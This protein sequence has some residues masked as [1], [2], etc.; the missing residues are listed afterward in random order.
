MRVLICAV[1]ALT[2]AAVHA[3]QP[4]SPITAPAAV[5]SGV[6]T[7]D[8][9]VLE[10]VPPGTPVR[11]MFLKEITSHTAHPGDRFRMRV[12][13]PVYINGKPVIPVGTFAWGEV[14]SLESNGAAGHAGKIAARLLY[15]DLPQGHLPLRGEVANKGGGNGGGVLLA[16]A[17]FGPLGLLTQGDSARFK[18]G[19]MLTAYVDKA[20]Q[21]VR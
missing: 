11:L 20:T 7:P 10:L 6:T 17:G 14:V 5:L 21:S 15:L 1:I 13:E 19:D 18:A 16:I 4:L 2:G 12:D 8:N 3:G 9:T